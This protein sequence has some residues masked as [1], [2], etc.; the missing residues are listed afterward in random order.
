MPK[1]ESVWFGKR[2]GLF[3]TT[4][5]KK[6][7]VL[8]VVT[9]SNDYELY[10]QDP[11]YKTELCKQKGKCPY[12]ENCRYAHGFGELRKRK[13]RPGNYKSRKCNEFHHG[14]GVCPYHDRCSFI[15]NMVRKRLKCFENIV[16]HKRLKYVNPKYLL[17]NSE[18]NG[19]L[20]E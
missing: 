15:H 16:S 8:K 7:Q 13:G 1:I 9:K 11:F 19:V 6:R 10:S 2:G 4:I 5:K 3:N 20:N 14:D 12:G 17:E 18:F